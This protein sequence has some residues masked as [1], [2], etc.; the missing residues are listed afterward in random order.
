MQDMKNVAQL[1]IS[2]RQATTNNYCYS[3]KY[4]SRFFIKIKII[5]SQVSK[6]S[7]IGRG[8]LE[9]DKYKIK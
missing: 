7:S 1:G 3:E 8:Q 4:P 9:V 5:L 2:S 6:T